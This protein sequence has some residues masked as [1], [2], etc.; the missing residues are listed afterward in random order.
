M[1]EGRRWGRNNM[2][3][4]HCSSACDQ[5]CKEPHVPRIPFPSF[6]ICS[7]EQ[8]NYSAVGQAYPG[9]DVLLRSEECV[10]PSDGS[11]YIPAVARPPY[12]PR[13]AR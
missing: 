9:F 4:L 2:E 6:S 8:T 3:C 11:G 10:E 1:E 12:T 7:K 13:A 5:G